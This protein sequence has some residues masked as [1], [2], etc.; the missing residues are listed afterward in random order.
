MK[1]LEANMGN[2]STLQYK[3]A[4][5]MEAALGVSRRQVGPVSL[6]RSASSSSSSYVQQSDIEAM[7]ARDPSTGKR[8]NWYMID[9]E[10]VEEIEEIA[11][12]VKERESS[13]ARLHAKFVNPQ[14][15]QVRARERAGSDARSRSIREANPKAR[16]PGVKPKIEF[17]DVPSRPP[18]AQP[19]PAK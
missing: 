9:E 17:V 15:F 18:A 16:S 13:R 2:S 10:N 7:V 6:E 11:R 14:D 5:A 12:E 3:F 8:A 1:A 19:R 4:N